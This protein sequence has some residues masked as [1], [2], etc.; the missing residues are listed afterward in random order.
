MFC[1]H[2]AVAAEQ[3]RNAHLASRYFEQL[4]D[5]PARNMDEKNYV[6]TIVSETEVSKELFIRYYDAF[7]SQELRIWIADSL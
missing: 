5:V 7:P 4:L 1:C 6:R 2:E 3:T